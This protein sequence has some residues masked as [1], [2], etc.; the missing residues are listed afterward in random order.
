M[1]QI[2][3]NVKLNQK[4]NVVIDLTQGVPIPPSKLHYCTVYEM[5]ERKI[6]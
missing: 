6:Q 4:F 1:W 3:S 2:D 5:I